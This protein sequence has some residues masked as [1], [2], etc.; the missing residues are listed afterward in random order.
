MTGQGLAERYMRQLS[1]GTL[2]AVNRSG[3]KAETE[4]AHPAE[5]TREQTARS[6]ASQLTTLFS[7]PE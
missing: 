5:P 3:P 6:F 1:D 2:A 7:A 4:S